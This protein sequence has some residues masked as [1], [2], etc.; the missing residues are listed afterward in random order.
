MNPFDVSRLE[1][2]RVRNHSEAEGFGADTK[3]LE[4]VDFVCKKNDIKVLSVPLGHPLLEGSDAKIIIDRRL[5]LARNDVGADSK[6]F[7]IAHE[8]GHFFLHQGVGFIFGVKIDALSPSEE[9]TVANHYVESYGPRER[10][11]LQANVFAREFLL[12]RALARKFFLEQMQSA[13][14]ISTT[15]EV[16]LELVRLQLYDALLLPEVETEQSISL[17]LKEPTLAQKP[18]VDSD[19]SVTLVEAGPGTGKTTTLLLRLQRLLANG[20]DPSSVLVLTYSNKAARELVDRS[21]MAGIQ[22]ID[23]VLTGTFHSFCLEFLR[24][25][26]HLNDL[27]PEVPIL[28]DLGALT[29]LSEAVPS[30]DLKNY[31][32]LSD[33]EKW[34]HDDVLSAIRRAKDELVDANAYAKL[35]VDHPHSD[36]DLQNKRLDT[37]TIFLEYER[38]LAKRKAVDFSDLLVCTVQLLRDASSSVEEYRRQFKHV[39]V[40]EYQDVNRASAILVKE[41]SLHAETL[42]VVG[43]ANQAIYGFMG[44]SNRNLTDFQTDF[45]DAQSIPL[46]R[47]HRSTQDIVDVFCEVAARNPSGRATH[48]MI[49]ETDGS[50]RPCLHMSSSDNEEV[51]L[52]ANS[53]RGIRKQGIEF[54]QQAILTYK[55]S[56][57]SR[58]AQGLELQ[59]IPV[60][61]LGNIFERP[62][63]S[64]LICMMRLATDEKGSDLVRSWR[65][66]WLRMSMTD[67]DII[68]EQ[69]DSDNPIPWMQRKSTSLSTQG[70]ASFNSLK[71]ITERIN[72]SSSPWDALAHILLEDGLL[73]RE[74]CANSSQQE[75]N[76]RMAI[77]QFVHFSRAPDGLSR[78]ATVKNFPERIKTRVRLNE[79]RMLRHVPPEAEGLNAVKIITAHGSKGLEFDAVHFLQVTAKIYAP[80]GKNQWALLPKEVFSS[81]SS[82]EDNLQI[83][84]HNLLYVALSRARKLLMV[85]GRK[86]KSLPVALNDLLVEISLDVSLITENN[87]QNGIP[88][89][90]I[91]SSIETMKLEN[92]FKLA[93]CGRSFE[94]HFRTGGVP[95][96]SPGLH[97]QIDWVVRS[98]VKIMSMDPIARNPEHFKE[99]IDGSLKKYF[100]NEHPASSAIRERTFSMA[101]QAANWLSEGGDTGSTISL[102]L[103]PLSVD[104]QPQ[105]IFEKAGE[106]IIRLIQPKSI[107]SKKQSLTALMQAH[108][109]YSSEKVSIEVVALNDGSKNNMTSVYKKTLENYM[110]L[111]ASACKNEFSVKPDYFGCP[112]CPF[113]FSCDKGKLN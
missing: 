26:G 12:P 95:F 73:L 9:D 82:I 16:P 90:V 18:A 39:L 83:E 108:N 28:D 104:L 58:L 5:V 49:A 64:D 40:D 61:F 80:K 46:D 29:M 33:P 11:E 112:R 79:D 69:Y 62:E 76:A 4:W 25:F 63:I 37:A 45:P 74:S 70:K 36:L 87:R 51:V 23:K 67:V 6:A 27:N 98:V 14:D 15:L 41:L 113:Y 57:A 13:S 32:A 89:E 60:L 111:A 68:L 35:V 105:Q 77:W 99:V 7:L 3:G 107:G 55:N 42:W 92:Y 22:G 17:K 101:Q 20:V 84:R 72:P 65:S 91:S 38:L 19:H 81:D 88:L 94:L 106:T 34:L 24:K 59:G 50:G 96:L 75:A 48:K 31:D 10:Q 1:A 56:D 109:Q 100:L 93:R 85:Y 66:L 2:A 43:D 53:I 54:S 44:A 8:L 47:N 78:W 52:L 102:E 97:L 21:S 71:S 103:G 86:D 30:L 110:D